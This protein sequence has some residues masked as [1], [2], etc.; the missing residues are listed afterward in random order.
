[1][2]RFLYGAR[3]TDYLDV[4]VGINQSRQ[5][6]LNADRDL[7]YSYEIRVNPIKTFSIEYG[8]ERADT[9]TMASI[10]NDGS[11]SK[12][13]AFGSI[14][15]HKVNLSVWFGERFNLEL[16]RQAEKVEPR[17]TV[18]SSYGAVHDAGEKTEIV[19]T[20]DL[21]PKL[22]LVGKLGE[23]YNEQGIKIY[24]QRNEFA[25]IQTN[26]ADLFGALGI[27]GRLQSFDFSL[28]LFRSV[29]DFSG[30][31]KTF[32]EYLPD[33]ISNVDNID[34]SM[35]LGSKMAINGCQL[36]LNRAIS[37]RLTLKGDFRYFSM[38]F[39]GDANMWNSFFFGA[40][41]QLDQ[42]YAAPAK[43]VDFVLGGFGLKYALK[44]E[45]ELNY[46]F[47]QLIPVLVEG[48]AQS[49]GNAGSD[50]SN[51][52]IASGGNTQVFSLAYYF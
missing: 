17:P 45:L 46:T 22:K 28:N 35:D 12:Y 49:P 37:E 16:R 14:D 34:K 24:D 47:R 43:R 6:D 25:Y 4:G 23:R 48:P 40:V 27:V 15:K 36:S 10:G 8:S 13:L 44:E 5:L 41:K 42:N 3:L 1:M 51:D 2:V 38:L 11:W 33:M 52:S 20:C 30:Q 9:G 50:F 7:G 31:G 32:S 21:N 19:T 26:R 29:I 39:D 18:L